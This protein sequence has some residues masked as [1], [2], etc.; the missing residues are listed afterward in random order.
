VFARI[1][2]NDAARKADPDAGL[3]IR[4]RQA[5][6]NLEANARN[7]WLIVGINIAAGITCIAISFF[8]PR[9][10]VI[11]MIAGLVLLFGV[12]LLT[13]WMGGSYRYFDHRARRS[14]RG[15]GRWLAGWIGGS[16]KAGGRASVIVATRVVNVVGRTV[17]HCRAPRENPAARRRSRR[18]RHD[19]LPAATS[20]RR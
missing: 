4:L 12:Q 7:V 18:R 3:D 6:A 19:R 11:P 9:Y 5:R 10:P 14:Q 2:L 15:L 17:F 8:V 1:E 13:L 16:E 20:P